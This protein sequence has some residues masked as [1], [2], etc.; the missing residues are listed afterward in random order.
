M[1]FVKVL[2]IT[3][4]Y[5]KRYNKFIFGQLAVPLPPPPPHYARS[6]EALMFHEI[7]RERRGFVVPFSTP[8]PCLNLV[9]PPPALPPPS[10][11]KRGSF[12]LSLIDIRERR[13]FFLPFSTLIP[14]LNSVFPPP[15]RSAE[16][17]TFHSL[18]KLLEKEDNSLFHSRPSI[19][20]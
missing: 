1:Y 2:F 12:D 13:R 20:L 17:L 18:M 6:A 4:I 14:C 5:E 9:P 16:A 15:A 7:I 19:L 8:N 10:R 3:K 11:A